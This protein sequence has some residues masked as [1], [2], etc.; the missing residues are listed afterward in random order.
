MSI[1]YALLLSTGR[2]VVGCGTR[3]ADLMRGMRFGPVGP[4]RPSFFPIGVLYDGAK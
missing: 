1:W 3:G 4:F 2:R